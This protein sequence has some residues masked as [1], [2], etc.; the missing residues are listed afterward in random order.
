[1]CRRTSCR[2]SCRRGSSD[3][4]GRPPRRREERPPRRRPGAC[5]VLSSPSLCSVFKTSMNSSPRPYLNVTRRQSIQRGT[6]RTS[7]CSTFTH[8]IGPMP[9]GNVNTSGS[10][11]GGSREPAA[12]LLPDHGRVQALLDRGPDREARRELVPLDLQVRAVADADLV[13]RVEQLVGGVAREH[14]RH[15]G[16]DADPDEGEL[17]RVSSH[18]SAAANCSSPSFT[19]ASSSRLVGVRLRQRHRH[20]EVRRARVE[21]AVEDR[22]HE[23]R[24]D[25]VQDRVGAVWTG[26]LG[27]GRGVGSRRPAR[28]RTAVPPP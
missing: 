3:P 25:G 28:P 26:Q 18:R 6:S 2:S 11:N 22:H 8:S 13:D 21:R 1:M 7:S 15:A 10:L 12:V 24:I 17:A 27:D 5:S 20:V 4:A 23:A 9:S 19:P 16:L 14:V